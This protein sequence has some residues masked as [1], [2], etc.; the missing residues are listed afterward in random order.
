MRAAALILVLT[1]ASPAAITAACELWCLQA[2]HHAAAATDAGGCHS[3]HAAAPGT[4]VV[5]GADGARCHDDSEAPRAI[6][7]G[8][9]PLAFVPAVISLAPALFSDA[10][11]A[12]AVP[13]STRAR[14]PDVL[15]TT[16]Q[17]RI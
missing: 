16:T 12:Q 14:P 15:L 2:L 13:Y 17:L 10:P 11:I 5:A 4:F 8:T 1:L 9:A 3:G 6:V 7:K